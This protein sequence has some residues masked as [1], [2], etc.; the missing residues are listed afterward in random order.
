VTPVTIH[1]TIEIKGSAE[2]IWHYVGT[3][4]GLRHWWGADIRMDERQGGRC[5][6][7]SVLHGRV[8]HL[9]GEVTV[10]DPP[11]RLVLVLRAPEHATAWPSFSTISLTLRETDD[12]T[13][14]EIEHQAFGALPT[15]QAI[16]K[17]QRREP[18][19]P[20]ILN[21][22]PMPSATPKNREPQFESVWPMPAPLAQPVDTAWRAQ[23]DWRWIASLASLKATSEE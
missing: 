21:Q 8:Q 18:V 3:E 19:R 6:E 4:A 22:L 12:H 15:E 17:E 20:A 2:Q 14:V 23:L 11:H 13:L 16:G 1:Q 7:R 10:Y 9:C 5:E